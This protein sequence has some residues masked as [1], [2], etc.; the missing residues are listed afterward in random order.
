[1]PEPPSAASREKGKAKGEFASGWIGTA[2]RDFCSNSLARSR[3]V[4]WKVPG[5]IFR[6]PD[7]KALFTPGLHQILDKKN[8]FALA[9]NVHFPISAIPEQGSYRITEMEGSNQGLLT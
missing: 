8:S 3:S 1:M 7:I 9:P 4:L 2:F 5:K 6:R